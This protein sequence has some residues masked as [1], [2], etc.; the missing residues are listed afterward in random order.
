MSKII[1]KFI[2]TNTYRKFL[3]FEENDK[4]LNIDDFRYEE[5]NDEVK[6]KVIITEGEYKGQEAFLIDT[7]NSYHIYY[8]DKKYMIIEPDEFTY[9]HGSYSGADGTHHYLLLMFKN[10]QLD[11]IPDEFTCKFNGKDIKKTTCC[12]KECFDITDI[13]EY[14]V[15]K[16]SKLHQHEYDS[17]YKYLF[18]MNN[19]E[20]LNLDNFKYEDDYIK[21]V[22][23]IKVS[24]SEKHSGNQAFLI[25][26]KHTYKIYY[27]D[28][29][30][31]ELEPDLY[32]FHHII[33]T[34]KDRHFLSMS[35]DGEQIKHVPEEFTCK[36][37]GED[38]LKTWFCDT[39]YFN[40]SEIGEYDIFKDG[41]SYCKI[42]TEKTWNYRVENKQRNFI[43]SYH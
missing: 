23:Q 17:N 28:R 31:M 3:L 13:G 14:I 16:D 33:D 38:V 24:L 32:D 11:E 4:I 40:I 26:K 2:E 36:L 37:N 19:E 42:I 7:D 22:S 21:N 41:K 12:G 43:I 34:E 29:F 25:H 8:K 18:F 10:V 20:I 15:Y 30:F 35:F 1:P 6:F 39:K 5:N 9:G 27:N